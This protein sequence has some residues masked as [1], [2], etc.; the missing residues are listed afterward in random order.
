M[1]GAD[2]ALTLP[3][4]STFTPSFTRRVRVAR[5]PTLAASRRASSAWGQG[6][7]TVRVARLYRDAAI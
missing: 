7:C 4:A 5:S 2:V 1:Q 3:M 6:A